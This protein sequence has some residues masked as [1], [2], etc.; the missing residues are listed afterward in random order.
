[1]NTGPRQ[2]DHQQM[3][4]TYTVCCQLL[5]ETSIGT[6]A[7]KAVV[8]IGTIAAITGDLPSVSWC[9]SVAA[10]EYL[11]IGGPQARQDLQSGLHTSRLLVVTSH[12]VSFVVLL[13][14]SWRPSVPIMHEGPAI[15]YLQRGG[16]CQA[17]STAAFTMPCQGNFAVTASFKK[18]SQSERSL[19]SYPSVRCSNHVTERGSP[20]TRL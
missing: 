5:K 17:T 8:R 6:I 14:L 15:G 12:F 4:V 10:R 16:T 13:P 3:V 19:E 2:N 18:R 11:P 1:M 7:I 20:H 9:A